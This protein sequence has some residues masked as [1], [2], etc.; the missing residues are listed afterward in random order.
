MILCLSYFWGVFLI[1][2]FLA[3]ECLYYTKSAAC[4]R[5]IEVLLMFFE[6][7]VSQILLLRQFLSITII[8][9]ISP[10]DLIGGCLLFGAASQSVSTFALA[11][12]S[13]SE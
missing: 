6:K 12:G 2:V 1:L 3:Y 7:A 13:C 4:Q 8:D 5:G 11:V 10:P 9:R